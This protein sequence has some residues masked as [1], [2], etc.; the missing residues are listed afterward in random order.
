M[1]LHPGNGDSFSLKKEIDRKILCCYNSENLLNYAYV[2]KWKVNY[3]I[4]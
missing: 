4:S 1:S 2:K 3:L